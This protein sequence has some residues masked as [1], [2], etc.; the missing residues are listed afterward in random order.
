MIPYDAI[1]ETIER[2]IKARVQAIS[3]DLAKGGCAD[4]P[5]YR[6]QVGTIRGLNDALEAVAEAR[7]LLH[8]QESET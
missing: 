8:V 6:T 3:E 1:S 5:S 7:R 2:L 4:F